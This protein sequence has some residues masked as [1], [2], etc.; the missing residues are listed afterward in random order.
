[1][2]NYLYDCEKCGEIKIRQEITD[3]LL[4]KCPE[5][6]G[7]VS[8]SIKGFKQGLVYNKDIE[9]MSDADREKYHKDPERAEKKRRAIT[10]G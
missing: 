10:G 6:E 1:M 8:R 3:D 9:Y 2:P 5:C 4:S 7:K